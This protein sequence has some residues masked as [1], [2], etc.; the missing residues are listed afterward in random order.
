[1]KL[2]TV[3]LRTSLPDRRAILLRQAARHGCAVRCSRSFGSSGILVDSL[4]DLVKNNVPS[5][6]LY[7]GSQRYGRAETSGVAHP[8]YT[9]SQDSRKGEDHQRHE[10]RQVYRKQES[11]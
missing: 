6:R 4:L 9:R 8:Y 1:M 5:L 7:H 2:P 3:P 11:V 10:M